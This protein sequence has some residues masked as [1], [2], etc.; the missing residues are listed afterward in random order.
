[1]FYLGI[2][3]SKAKLDCELRNTSTEK[4]KSKAIP[5]TSE[6]F[7][8]LLEWLKK[9]DA[10]SAHVILEPTGVYHEAAA[11]FFADA[12][13]T[14]S[15][16]NPAQVRQFAQGIGKKNKTD[17]MDSHVLARF[18]AT[19][20]PEAWQPPSAS[21]RALKALLARRDAI[22]DD[23]L[24]EKNRR[25]KLEATETPELVTQSVEQSIKFIE[26]EIKRLE[27]SIDDLIDNDPDMRGKKEL[28]T[29]I[30]GVG[31]R[32]SN[33]MTCLLAGRDFKSAE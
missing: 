16:V 11:F 22:A 27:K 29:S 17:K 19:Q 18:G 12:G 9:N 15:L 7:K 4:V 13:F 21:A 31:E 28:L 3:V 26:A 1:M 10:V 24:R 30:P 25:E 8:K 33:H 2:D 6:G 20:K 32:V 23:L 14:I 5:N